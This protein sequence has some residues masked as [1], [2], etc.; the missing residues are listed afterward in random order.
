MSLD[1][2]EKLLAE[3][4]DSPMLRFGL[5]NSYLQQGDHLRAAEHF[6]ACVAQDPHYSA[7]W[8]MLGRTLMATG[9]IP[10]AR[11]ALA[12]ALE[13]ARARGDKQ[14]EREAGVFLGKLEKK[15][16]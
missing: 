14:V 1:A 3:G 7:A 12:R 15:S 8:K 11:A 6:R 10:G 2:L 4:R 16:V 13:E 5:G 9:D